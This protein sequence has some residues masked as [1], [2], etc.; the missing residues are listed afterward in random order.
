MTLLLLPPNL[1][2]SA[3]NA[4][5]TSARLRQLVNQALLTD[6]AKFLH[7]LLVSPY[8][9]YFA[10]TATYP[11]K[12]VTI[13]SGLEHQNRLDSRENGW[14]CEVWRALLSWRD[15]NTQPERGTALHSDC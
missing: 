5:I 10:F 4:A 7:S 3:R 1:R 13:T 11:P 6:G 15:D 14:F 9:G 8:F 2:I 12:Q